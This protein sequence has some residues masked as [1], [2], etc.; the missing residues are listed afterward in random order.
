LPAQRARPVGPGD[1]APEASWTVRRWLVEPIRGWIAPT[2][3]SLIGGGGLIGASSG[4]GTSPALKKL[5]PSA[6][7][8]ALRAPAAASPAGPEAGDQRRVWPGAEEEPPGGGAFQRPVR[9]AGGEGRS[10]LGTVGSVYTASPPLT[11]SVSGA[12]GGPSNEPAVG[13]PR[14][15]ERDP[16]DLGRLLITTRGKR[17]RPGPRHGETTITATQC[18]GQPT[19]GAGSR[20]GGGR[21]SALQRGC[22]DH[23]EQGVRPAVVSSRTNYTEG[24]AHDRP[25]DG[26]RTRRQT[27][28]PHGLPGGACVDRVSL[29][30]GEY[31]VRLHR[32]STGPAA[33]IF[34]NQNFTVVGPTAPSGFRVEHR[35][36]RTQARLASSPQ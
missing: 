4:A 8:G 36:G 3:R 14:I 33:H 10:I 20:R 12:E 11:T 16:L 29:S 6:T 32:T 2:A 15:P 22:T 30:S 18:I 27:G 28:R 21:G 23:V 7:T 34:G 9:T 26:Q 13:Q 19:R 24:S 25:R 31:E 5:S 17:T 35:S 1:T